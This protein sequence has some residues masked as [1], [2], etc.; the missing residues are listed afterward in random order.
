M[1]EEMAARATGQFPLSIATSLAIESACGIHPDIPAT[2]P[3]ILKFKEFWVNVKTL[4]RNLLGSLDRESAEIV[5]SHA[6]GQTLI[7]EMETI[8]EVIKTYSPGTKVV[9]YI[10]EYLDMKQLY[11]DALFRFETTEKRKHYLDLLDQTI[12]QYLDKNV[13]LGIALSIRKLK[14]KAYVTAM[15][16]T[17]LP[18]D[19]LSRYEF[20]DLVLLESHTG[21]I[22]PFAQWYTKYYNGN[23]LTMLPFREELLQIFGDDQTFRPLSIKLRR[24]IVQ[25]ALARGWNAVTTKER[26]RSNLKDLPED[27]LKQ[28]KD[29]IG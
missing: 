27:L 29:I 25:I 11:P 17:H 20:E 8:K 3:P 4:F 24:A 9:F 22:K 12:E 16:L 23:E 6:M 19:L 15:I 5:S 28:I 14:P 7:L 26:I 13:E 21:A 2:K 1:M 10:N 18:Y